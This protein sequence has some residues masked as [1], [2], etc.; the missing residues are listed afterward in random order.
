[1]PGARRAGAPGGERRN[2]RRAP[3]APKRAAPRPAP[4]TESPAATSA[5]HRQTPRGLRSRARD[6]D[7]WCVVSKNAVSRASRAL[8]Y[9]GCRGEDLTLETPPTPLWEGAPRRRHEGWQGQERHA[10]CLP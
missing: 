9:G 10:V 4:Q 7:P 2:N 3:D 8:P 6:S 5:S 1:G